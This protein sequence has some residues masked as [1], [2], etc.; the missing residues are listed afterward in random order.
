MV[1]RDPVL[2]GS[3][4]PLTI[5]F[6]DATGVP[7]DPSALKVSVYPPTYDP[8][9]GAEDADAWVLDAT[10]TSGG[11]GD[12]ADPATLIT[13]IDTGRYQFSFTVPT[14]ADAGTAYDRWEATLNNASID[15]TFTFTVASGGVVGESQLYNNNAVY[16]KLHSTIAS[17][18]GETLGDDYETYFTTTYDPLYVSARRLRLELGNLIVNVPDDLINW[19]IFEAGLEAIAFT[20]GTVTTDTTSAYRFF[21]FARRQYVTCVAMLIL[22]TAMNNGEFGGGSKSKRLADLN[23]SFSGGQVDDIFRRAMS[24]RVKW[25]ATLTS[26]GEVGP[27][28]SSRPSM[29]VKGANDPDRPEFGRQWEPT[30]TYTSL[31][32]EYPAANTDVKQSIYHRRYRKTYSD[33]WESRFTRTDY[34]T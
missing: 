19:A 6:F 28:T 3:A 34:D 14:A 24:C 1:S 9:E 33:R 30:S 25:Q 15:E 21:E 18:D 7:T 27:G 23:I 17:T 10:T 16:I 22:L 31:G 2:R 12:Y 5:T 4:I 11:T 32:S 8:R 20:F 26:A 13:K 29:V